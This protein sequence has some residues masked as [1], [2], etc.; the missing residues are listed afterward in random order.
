MLTNIR[1]SISKILFHYDN[2]IHRK[3][4]VWSDAIRSN[5]LISLY[6]S[7]MNHFRRICCKTDGLQGLNEYGYNTYKNS[8][9]VPEVLRK[10]SR[11]DL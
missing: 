7:D 6:L 9:D 11:S 10:K 1:P 4:K 3:A 5:T 2:V 8:A